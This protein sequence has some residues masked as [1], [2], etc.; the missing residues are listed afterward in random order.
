MPTTID[1]IL[2][3]ALQTAAKQA[4]SVIDQNG[5]EKPSFQEARKNV[6]AAQNGPAPVVERASQPVASQ[7]IAA[8]PATSSA[9][10]SQSVQPAATTQPSATSQ[11]A[12]Q[13]KPMSYAEMFVAMNPYRPQT[14]EEREAEAK[15]NKRNALFAAISDGISALS[16]LY[17]TTKGAPNSFNGG[18]T[19]SG[20]MYERQR[21]LQKDREAREKEYLNGYLRA[22]E[23]DRNRDTQERNYRLQL[24]TLAYN[25]QRQAEADKRAAAK[26]ARD[27]ALHDLNLKYKQG[28]LDKQQYDKQAAE[29][30]AKYADAYERARIASLNRRGSGGGG[31]STSNDLWPYPIKGENIYLPKTFWSNAGE[32]NG[33]YSML[34]AEVRDNL[35]H[36]YNRNGTVKKNLKPTLDQKRQAIMDNATSEIQDRL[37]TKSKEFGGTVTHTTATL[38]PV[39]PWMGSKDSTSTSNNA[40]WL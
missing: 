3:K 37:R 32:V 6:F 15:R 40:P 28:Q 2:N 11:P 19:L 23:M 27:A 9:V 39:A 12:T 26:D 8:Q 5:E 38:P 4:G 30:K 24:E 33:L 34:P 17:Y 16:N 35:E 29:I 18:S 7:P 14:P 25:R 22:L 13:Q 10:P 36:E 21:Q 1:D 20:K 31:G